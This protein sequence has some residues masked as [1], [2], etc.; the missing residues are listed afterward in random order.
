M[1][2][3]DKDLISGKNKIETAIARIKMHC[4]NKRI[5]CA[6]SGGKDSQCV[7][8]LLKM[9]GLEFHAEYSITRF[10]PPELLQFIRD[11]YKDVTFRRAYGNKSLVKQIEE[12]GLP[13]RWCRWCCAAKHKK[14]IGFDIACIGIRWA[15]SARRR[16]RWNDFGR[17]DDGTFYCCPIVDWSDSDVWEF[18]NSNNI[19]HCSLYDEGYKRIGCVCCPLSPNKGDELRWPK[20]ANVLKMGWERYYERMRQKGFLNRRGEVI[21]E[22]S[23]DNAKTVCFE[24]WLRGGSVLPLKGGVEGDDQPCLFAGTGFSE[25]DGAT[26]ES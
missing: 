6:F 1:S 19:P 13:N 23:G 26:D 12:S 25:S 14:T 24:N 16:M 10:E 5:L 22:I 4:A 17:K 18:L 21:R 3:F 20:F 2:I 8:H 15:E 11:N 7:Y 9:S